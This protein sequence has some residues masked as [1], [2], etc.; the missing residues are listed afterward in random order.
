MLFRSAVRRNCQRSVEWLEIYR[1][2]KS[3][4]CELKLGLMIHLLE[5]SEERRVG[6]EC[7]ITCILAVR[8]NCQRSVEWLE[9]YRLMKS[10]FCE[11]KLGLMIHFLEKICLIV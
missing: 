9:I 3:F 5:R 10:F 1:L 11:L 7:L 8:R 4:F 2:M 6:T